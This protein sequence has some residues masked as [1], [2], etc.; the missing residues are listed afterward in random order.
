MRERNVAPP[1][2]PLGRYCDNERGTDGQTDGTTRKHAA[3]SHG[4]HQQRTPAI[5]VGRSGVPRRSAPGV[6]GYTRKA[7]KFLTCHSG[8]RLFVG[9]F[10]LN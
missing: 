5:T 6:I 7:S 8:I 3:R 2:E 10:F 4:A 9:F 1:E